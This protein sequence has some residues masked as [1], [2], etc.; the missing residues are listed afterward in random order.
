[1]MHFMLL[2][3]VSVHI[4]DSYSQPAFGVMFVMTVF[5]QNFKVSHTDF[6]KKNPIGIL[7]NINS[8]CD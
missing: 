1:M 6:I 7:K 4:C 5:M 3:V 8:F 2:C